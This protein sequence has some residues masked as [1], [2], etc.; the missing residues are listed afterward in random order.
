MIN[1]VEIIRETVL[2]EYYST[3]DETNIQPHGP[4]K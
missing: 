2:S 1:F 4:C 3:F